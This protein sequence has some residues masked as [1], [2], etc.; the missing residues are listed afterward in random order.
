MT[1]VAYHQKP[2]HH[3]LQEGLDFTRQI[4]I[5][6]ERAERYVP[7]FQVAKQ[8]GTSSL[9]LA[10]VSSS[11]YVISKSS[12]QR[13]NLG[14]NLKFDSKR[15]KVLG[16]SR[17]NGTVWEYSQKAIDLIKEYKV[18]T[19]AWHNCVRA[20]QST[21]AQKKVHNWFFSI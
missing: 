2:I 8:I 9:A 3:E 11:L 1:D 4:A 15:K 7:S 17:K 18:C 13:T 14:L 20:T 5:D 21:P 10:K 19:T 6:A 16:F 12:D